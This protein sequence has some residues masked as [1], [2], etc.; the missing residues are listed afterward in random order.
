MGLVRLHFRLEALRASVGLIRPPR[1][2]ALQHQNKLWAPDQ[3]RTPRAIIEQQQQ[4][5][6]TL[7][8]MQ[9]LDLETVSVSALLLGI[10]IIVV[11]EKH[12]AS[13][14][15]LRR[16]CCEVYHVYCVKNFRVLHFVVLVCV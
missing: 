7:P 5:V 4:N 13:Q 12:C 14:R 6:F 2:D 3:W 10:P 15:P 16:F 9:A 1:A 8:S 11:A